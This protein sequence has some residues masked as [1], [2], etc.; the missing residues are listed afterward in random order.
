MMLH[1]RDVLEEWPDHPFTAEIKAKHIESLKAPLYGND[2]MEFLYLNGDDK[3]W[4]WGR[5]GSTNAAFIHGEAR[6]YFRQYF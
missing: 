2:F 3:G 4:N 6:D 5:N 1:M